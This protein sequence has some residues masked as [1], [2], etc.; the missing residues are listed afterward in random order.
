MRELTAD[1]AAAGQEGLLVEQWQKEAMQLGM[2]DN[3]VWDFSVIAANLRAA[4]D[5]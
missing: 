3:R 1:V 2:V 4:D 5:R